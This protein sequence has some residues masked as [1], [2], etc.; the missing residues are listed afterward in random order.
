MCAC[1]W[2][3]GINLYFNS[4]RDSLFWGEAFLTGLEV[5]GG[6]LASWA[7]WRASGL[8]FPSPGITACAIIPDF[9]WGDVLHLYFSAA[10]ARAEGAFVYLWRPE[11][12]QQESPVSF[13]SSIQASG[14]KVRSLGLVTVAFTDWA[15]LAPV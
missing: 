9:V 1:V 8:C 4:S 5:S 15:W 14:T 3:P 13:P 10:C 6:G 12:N 11:D 7:P 2:R